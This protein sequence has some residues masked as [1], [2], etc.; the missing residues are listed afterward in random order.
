VNCWKCH[1][2]VLGPVCV[3][4][5]AISPPRPGADHFAALGLRRSFH[6]DAAEVERAWRD[7]SRLVHPD[8]FAGRSAVERR[9]SL[10]W[11]A[12]IN[13]ARRVLRDPVRRAR[14]LATGQPEPAES[15]QPA[16]DADFLEEVFDLQMELG[17]DPEGVR[18]RAAS[19]RGALMDEVDALF[20]AWERDGADLGPVVER[21]ARV[22]YLDNL[23]A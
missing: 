4:C 23:I 9:M 10:Q 2:S 20:A 11:T 15:G 18:D 1:E 6:L 16:L 19:L 21:L 7:R 14:Y 3:G 5:G 13:E 17:A 22:K 8:R 12:A